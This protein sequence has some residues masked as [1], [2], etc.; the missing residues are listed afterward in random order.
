MSNRPP[1]RSKPMYH[2]LTATDPGPSPHRTRQSST[3]FY[4]SKKVENFQPRPPRRHTGHRV[5]WQPTLY[6]LLLR[7]EGNTKTTK[8]TRQSAHQI[9]SWIASHRETETEA[10][11]PTDREEPEHP[12]GTRRRNNAGSQFL[13]FSKHS[14][15]HREDPSA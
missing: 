5:R 2:H 12:V 7:R 9:S 4:E 11:H 8:E 1:G 3:S 6:Y 15:T 13:I 14:L 10:C